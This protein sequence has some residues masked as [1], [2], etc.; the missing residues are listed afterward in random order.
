MSLS[1]Y[2]TIQ[3]FRM[4]STSK[5]K[6]EQD[7]LYEEPKNEV[8]H[9]GA[10]SFKSLNKSQKISRDTIKMSQTL[11]LGDLIDQ[12][13]LLRQTLSPRVA[14]QS[15]FKSFQFSPRLNKEDECRRSFAQTKAVF[16]RLQPLQNAPH[17]LSRGVEGKTM[18]QAMSDVLSNASR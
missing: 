11:N 4:D 15:V 13:T 7:S 6:M 17:R 10:H 12:P 2:R 1:M 18:K 3:G 5:V 8:S 9:Y 14:Q 16:Q